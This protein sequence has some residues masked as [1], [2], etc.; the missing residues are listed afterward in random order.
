MLLRRRAETGVFLLDKILVDQPKLVPNLKG[1]GPG[2]GG[3][4][5]VIFA[6]STKCV[7]SLL[8]KV[9]FFMFCVCLVFGRGG[10]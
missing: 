8:W 1:G 9:C 4:F 2:G 10:V 5:L 3:Q 6:F 7:H